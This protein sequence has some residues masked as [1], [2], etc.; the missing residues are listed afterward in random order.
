[1]ALGGAGGAGGGVD[2]RF[3]DSKLWHLVAVF[4]GVVAVGWGGL[5]SDFKILRFGTWWCGG[6]VV[7][8]LIS[9]FK[10]LSFDTWWWWWCGGGGVDFRFPNSKV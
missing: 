3:R 10:I 6:G 2:F 1:M 7:V 4:G 5:I 9:D 8:D